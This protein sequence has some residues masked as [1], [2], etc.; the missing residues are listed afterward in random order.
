MPIVIVALSF[1][2]TSSAQK[3]GAFPL[4]SMTSS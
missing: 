4:S 3:S 1:V 2:T